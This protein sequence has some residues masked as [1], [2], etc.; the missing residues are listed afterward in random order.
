MQP[1]LHVYPKEISSF[2]SRKICSVYTNM[3]SILLKIHANLT[4]F[5]LNNNLKASRLNNFLNKI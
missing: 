5:N 4:E 1:N 2:D 3:K